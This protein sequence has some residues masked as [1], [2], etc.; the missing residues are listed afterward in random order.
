MV[1]FWAIVGVA[2]TANTINKPN[3]FLISNLLLGNGSFGT[4]P[5]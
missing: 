5:V 1:I 3:I 2:T 4:G